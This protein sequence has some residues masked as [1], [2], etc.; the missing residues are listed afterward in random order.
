[1]ENL[2]FYDL[3]TNGLDYDTTYIMQITIADNNRDILWNKYCYPM[4]GKINGSD[5]HNITKDVLQ[6]NNAMTLENCCKDMLKIINAF[7]GDNEVILI[8]YNNFGYDQ[9]ILE[10]NFEKVGLTIPKNWYFRDLLPLLRS[11]YPNT[12]PNYKLGTIYSIL[13][14]NPI[15]GS[16]H[17]SLTDVYC[18][19]DIYDYFKKNHLDIYHLMV[20]KYTRYSLKDKRILNCSLEVFLDNNSKKLLEIKGFY[21]VNDI[22]QKFVEFNF[23]NQIFDLY[24]TRNIG[25]YSDYIKTNFMKQLKMIE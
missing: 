7:Y 19:Y 15:Q 5:I 3:E 17:N 24:L 22:Y 4:D 20:N 16:L 21:I 10:K 1:M 23:D 6:K 8:A 18:L 11:L 2:L 14:D 13:C 12:F 25:I 9:I